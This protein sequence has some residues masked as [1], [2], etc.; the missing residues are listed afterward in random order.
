[1]A[2]FF[3]EWRW[4]CLRQHSFHDVL[5]PFPSQPILPYCMH[6]FS[7]LSPYQRQ[8]LEKTQSYIRMFCA[9]LLGFIFVLLLS[10]SSLHW[11]KFMVLKD[12]KTLFAGLWTVC[13]HDLCWSHV[14]KAPCECVPNP[15]ASS[16]GRFSQI[17]HSTPL[18]LCPSHNPAPPFLPSFTSM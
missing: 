8:L 5:L 11:V 13:H 7:S 16:F 4:R 15:R 2:Y 10:L 1:M 14:P 12:K 9:G 6:R 17:L 18:S 3:C